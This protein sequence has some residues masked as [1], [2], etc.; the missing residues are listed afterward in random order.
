MSLAFPYRNANIFIHFC[1]LCVSAPVI[2][3]YINRTFLVIVL[4]WKSFLLI[5]RMSVCWMK[6]DFPFLNKIQPTPHK[7]YIFRRSIFSARNCILA[8]FDYR[9]RNEH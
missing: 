6:M 3:I 5:K 4:H 9:W 1:L 8:L 2:C 7:K